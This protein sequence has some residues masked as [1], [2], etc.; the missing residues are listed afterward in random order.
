MGDIT[1]A[2]QLFEATRKSLPSDAAFCDAFAAANVSKNFLARYYLRAIATCDNPDGEYRISQH[3]DEVNLE[4]V[5]PQEPGENWNHITAEDAKIWHKRIGNLTIMDSA[6][7][8]AAANAPFVDRKAIY[9]QSRIEI[10]RSLSELSDRTLER[11]QD[12]Q[13]VLADKAVQVWPLAPRA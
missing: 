8:V 7:N 2:Q 4:H 12:H 13:N 3:H 6:L 1:T 5:L 9:A 11:I 10:A